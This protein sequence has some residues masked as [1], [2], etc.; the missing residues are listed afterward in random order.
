MSSEDTEGGV[1]AIYILT[2]IDLATYSALLL[3]GTRNTVKILVMQGKWRMFYL[4]MFY[5]C[6]F[7]VVVSKLVWF[8]I[9]L[10][11]LNYD[12]ETDP[13]PEKTVPTILIVEY[14]AN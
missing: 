9:G 5:V 7:F 3:F 2:C 13:T 1:T 8:S 10:Y 6:A 14:A 12:G 4:S 11:A